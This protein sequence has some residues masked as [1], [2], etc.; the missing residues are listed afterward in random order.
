MY[1]PGEFIE[2]QTTLTH[3]NNS[4]LEEHISQTYLLLLPTMKF[5]KQSWYMKSPHKMHEAEPKGRQGRHK[6][7]PN[8]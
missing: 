1:L 5:T 7:C 2:D 4:I 6:R 3:A 8:T